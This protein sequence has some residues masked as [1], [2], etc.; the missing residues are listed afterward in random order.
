M[1]TRR[2]QNLIIEK[3]L[4]LFNEHGTKMISTNRIADECRLSRGNLHYHFRTKEEII[5][6]IFQRI[7]KKMRES[8]FDDHLHPTMEYMQFMFARQI[9]TIWQYRFFYCELNALLQK[10]AHLKTL[11]IDNQ[12]IRFEEVALFFEEL[13]KAGLIKRPQP[14]A[15]LESVLQITWLITDQW[16]PYLYM[17]DRA[18]DEAN[19]GE[20]YQLI[21]QVL[22]PYLTDKG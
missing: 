13:A 6:A 5:Q 20:G 16:V 12:K 15:S 21:L 18:I 17:H 7:S 9:K 22:Q 3:A 4:C 1:S 11:F 8:W 14:P 19:I 2:T 10:D